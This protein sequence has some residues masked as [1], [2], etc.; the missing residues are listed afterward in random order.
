MHHFHHIP[1][2]SA[3]PGGWDVVAAMLTVA[4]IACL[5]SASRRKP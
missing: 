3:A 5:L 4:V 2:V 1:L